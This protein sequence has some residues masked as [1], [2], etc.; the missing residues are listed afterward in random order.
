MEH[1]YCGRLLDIYRLYV[2]SSDD[3]VYPNND[4]CP[5]LLYK[6]ALATFDKHDMPFS[7]ENVAKRLKESVL[8]SFEILA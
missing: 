5:V 6:M 7:K 1:V 8:N 4:L 3:G 2:K